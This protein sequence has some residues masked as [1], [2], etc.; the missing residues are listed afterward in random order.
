MVAE[1]SGENRGENPKDWVKVILSEVRNPLDWVAFVRSED[2]LSAKPTQGGRRIAC[3]EEIVGDRIV[4]R[5]VN[6]QREEIFYGRNNESSRASLY[7]RHDDL[8]GKKLDR[9]F[10]QEWAPW[11]KHGKK[12]LREMANFSGMA[13]SEFKD[14]YFALYGEIFEI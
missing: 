1:K 9:F 3:V 14:D 6:G 5:Y 12:G 13:F 11:A 7:Y 4:V 10:G 2:N 8:F